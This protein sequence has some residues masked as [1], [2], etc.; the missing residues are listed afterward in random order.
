MKKTNGKNTCETQVVDKVGGH[1][2]ALQCH[3]RGEADWS[4]VTKAFSGFSHEANAGSN[5]AV[6]FHIKQKISPISSNPGKKIKLK[7]A[8]GY[9]AFLMTRSLKIMHAANNLMQ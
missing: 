9:F 4:R 7:K 1:C 2:C 6:D 8:L 5:F 3:R